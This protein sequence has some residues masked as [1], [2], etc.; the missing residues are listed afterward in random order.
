M[1]R[2]TVSWH[3]NL[4]NSNFS[5]ILKLVNGLGIKFHNFL[6]WRE[7]H[8]LAAARNQFKCLVGWLHR[9]EIPRQGQSP[10]RMSMRRWYV[11]G[12][13]KRSAF[14]KTLNFEKRQDRSNPICYG[15]VSSWSQALRLRIR[16]VI[17]DQAN[18]FVA[19]KFGKLV[20]FENIE[21]GEG[22]RHQ[23]L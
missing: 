12:V 2:Q 1:T 15:L 18:R 22:F 21:A 19:P 4:E 9:R 23:I 6:R 5:K 13:L 3:R 16:K 7:F 17:S 14:L 10:N 11:F 8:C 20:F